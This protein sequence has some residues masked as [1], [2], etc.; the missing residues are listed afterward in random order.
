M[1]AGIVR[2]ELGLCVLDLAFN[3][4]KGPD[5]EGFYGNGRDSATTL[6]LV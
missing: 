6:P 4:L 1:Q 3:S 5:M 2:P